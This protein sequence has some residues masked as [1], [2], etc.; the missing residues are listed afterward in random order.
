MNIQ[1]LKVVYFSPTETTKKI[2]KYI[3]QGI[4]IDSTQF[5]DIT[6][7]KAREKQIET[8]KND[9]LLIAFPVYMGRV[10]EIV[11]HY[12]KKLTIENTPLV[13]LA[14]YGN[15]HFD[16]ALLEINNSLKAKGAIPFASAAF[17]GEHSFSTK[18]H[19]IA[20]SRPNKQDLD[21]A[22]NFGTKVKNKIYSIDKIMDSKE[23]IV[24]GNNPYGGVTQIWS[25]DFIYINDNCINKGKCAQVCPTGAIDTKNIRNI[26]IDKCISCCACIKACPQNARSIKDSKV[27][28]AS[29]RLNN[30]FK[31]PKS[32][33]FFI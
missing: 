1:N 30:L 9:I 32:P 29:I 8:N 3:A 21:L 13:S 26:N 5:Y 10:P 7:P 23:I 20:E 19:P 31:E 11:T 33:E 16:D 6:L 12:L 25:L 27:K 18:E 22:Y 17:I 15:R 14:V 2:A 28:D 24:P 4:N